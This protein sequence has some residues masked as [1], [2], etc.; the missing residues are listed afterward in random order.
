MSCGQCFDRNGRRLAYTLVSVAKVDGFEAGD[1]LKVSG[2]TKG[3]GFTGV[4]K[5][6]G[7]AGGPRTHGQSDRQRAPGSIGQGT[8]P[9]RV[10]KGKKMAGRSGNQKMTLS[11]V[12]LLE[13]NTKNKTFLIKGL[14][15]GGRKAPLLILRQEKVKQFV[16]LLKQGGALLFSPDA[17][18]QIKEESQEESKEEKPTE[19]GKPVKADKDDK[20]EQDGN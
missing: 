3:R 16:P 12:V 7:F 10:H 1:G 11:N 8:T 4:M 15:P 17:Q 5:R 19:E 18:A 6:W 13:V 2:Q 9:G 20:K 14:L